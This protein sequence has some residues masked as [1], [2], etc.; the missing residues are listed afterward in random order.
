MPTSCSVGYRRKTNSPCPLRP[1]KEFQSDHQ[2]FVRPSVSSKST[3]AW[4]PHNVFV[5]PHLELPEFLCCHGQ[6]QSASPLSRLTTYSH[7]T[8]HTLT[9]SHFNDLLHNN[10]FIQRNQVLLFSDKSVEHW[11][12][13]SAFFGDIK[14]VS[15]KSPHRKVSN[16]HGNH[17]GLALNFCYSDS[18]IHIHG[19]A[20]NLVR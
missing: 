3:S 20:T 5:C 18:H 6:A 1:P 12:K 14:D 17:K 9:H 19:P 10:F 4:W 13:C 2:D 7:D 15:Q 16:E 8:H 11:K